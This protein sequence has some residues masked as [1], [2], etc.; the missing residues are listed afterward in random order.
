MTRDFYHL[1]F[2]SSPEIHN[3][4]GLLIA[5]VLNG[6]PQR[7]VVQLNLCQILVQTLFVRVVVGKS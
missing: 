5:A 2:K 6:V 3:Q 1:G 7:T 4:Q